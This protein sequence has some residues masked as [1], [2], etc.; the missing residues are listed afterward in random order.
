M[1][2]RRL[3]KCKPCDGTGFVNGAT[4]GLV[5]NCH[6]CLGTGYSMRPQVI[7]KKEAAESKRGIKWE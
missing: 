1:K 6:Y 3:K 2:T 4:F 7:T 5:I